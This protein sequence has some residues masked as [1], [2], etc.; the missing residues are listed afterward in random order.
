MGNYKS[1]L[2]LV[3][4]Y[5]TN[6]EFR[7][8]DALDC[9]NRSYLLEIG[10][11]DPK[12]RVMRDDIEDRDVLDYR[13]KIQYSIENADSGQ[14]LISAFF[15]VVVSV[16]ADGSITESHEAAEINQWMEANAISLLYA[17][18]KASFEYMTAMS[19]VG[20][21]TLPTID[22]YTYMNELDEDSESEDGGL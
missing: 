1:P 18:A 19:P 13:L 11:P 17:K 12:P 21:Q 6:V 8:N 14:E 2:D 16:A 4:S 15:T 10:R 9:A 5:V 22:P 3:Y 20:I 7:I